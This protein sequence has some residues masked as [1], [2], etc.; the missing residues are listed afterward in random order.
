MVV[1]IVPLLVVPPVLFGRREWR[2]SPDAQ[3]RVAE[4]GA[5]LKEILNALRIVQVSSHG[6]PDQ[7]SFAAAVEHSAGALRRKRSRVPQILIAI[8]FGFGAI[9]FSL[10][11]W[12]DVIAGA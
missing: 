9:V 6:P 3:P 4:F 1:L 7:T 10:R 11:G 8:L 2:L 5:Y 12:R